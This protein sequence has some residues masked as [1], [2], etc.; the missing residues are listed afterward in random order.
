MAKRLYIRGNYIIA[1][2]DGVFSEYPTSR[3]VYTTT[4]T[5]YLV[6]EQI[7]NGTLVILYAEIGDWIN[8]ETG[9]TAFDDNSL[10]T[11]LQDNTGNFSRASAS[12]AMV[13]DI[14]VWDG[15]RYVPTTP[16]GGS[17]LSNSD[18]LI[19]TI[20]KR[21]IVLGG[22]L[23]TDKLAIENYARTKDIATFSENLTDLNT[24]IRV[25]QYGTANNLSFQGTN[26][27]I[28]AGNGNYL[29]TIVGY[30]HRFYT[31]GT[32]KGQWDTSQLYM[33]TS[34]NM[35][36]AKD[37]ILGSGVGTKIGTANSQKI[38]FWG[39]TPTVQQTLSTGVGATVDD[40]IGMLQIVGI[41]KQ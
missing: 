4:S 41:C 25:G 26:A 28:Y 31:Y 35:A 9:T 8:G 2:N 6:K 18:Q 22:S 36:N 24:N 15:T 38:G 33:Y 32:L 12:G 30:R 17:N 23:N 10:K 5:A 3:S 16:S 21:S 7:D 19:N 27:T 37:L 20:G 14:L 11:F 13:G 29:D 1:D 39:T 34:I 40:V